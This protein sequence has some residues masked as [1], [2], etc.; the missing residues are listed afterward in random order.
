MLV[1]WCALAGWNCREKDNE[2]VWLLLGV[3]EE[4]V[5]G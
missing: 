2:T 3:I 5:I 4:N 1:D